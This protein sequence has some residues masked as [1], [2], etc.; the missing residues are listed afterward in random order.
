MKIACIGEMMVDIIVRT[1]D[2]V[3]F[4]NGTDRVE[5]ISVKSG[6]DATNTAIVLSKLG[7][8]VKYIGLVGRDI[9]AD[10]AIQ[11]VRQQGVDMSDIVFSPDL[12]QP[13]SLI[14]VNS[15]KDRHFL[16]YTGT[17]DHFCIDHINMSVLDWADI[18]QIGGTY[19]LPAFDGEGAAEF[20]RMAREKNVLTSMDVTSCHDGH[21]HVIDPCLPFLD[22]FLPSE[23]HAKEISGYS[24]P[25][26]MAAYF[27]DRGVKNV[28]IKLG[29]K[30]SFCSNGSTSFYC[31]C[32][33]VPVVETTGAGDAYV[34][35][36][37]TGAGNGRPLEECAILGSACSAFVIQSFGSTEGMKDYNTVC[38]F[39][40]EARSPE[41]TYVK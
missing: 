18:V 38:R 24:N 9:F 12:Q 39:M 14:L 1:V 11:A 23:I 20:L 26:D 35:G 32:Y 7:N 25:E 34:A 31:G 41:V 30:G 17:S 16:E 28:V 15:S 13:K 40:E 19:H 27:L 29:S 6:G 33:D 10:V 2:N 22:Y 8:Q 37:L 36:F 21:L 5:D 3:P 4:D